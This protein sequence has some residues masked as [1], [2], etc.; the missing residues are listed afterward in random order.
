MI[1]SV[2]IG[3]VHIHTY[4]TH[5]YTPYDLCV[6]ACA[7]PSISYEIYTTYYSYSDPPG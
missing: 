1:A 7:C 3:D 4:Y 6:C 5:T 2:M